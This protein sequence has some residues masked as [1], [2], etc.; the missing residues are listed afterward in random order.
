MVGSVNDISSGNLGLGVT[1][2]AWSSGYK[3]FQVTPVAVLASGTGNDA[4]FSNNWVNESGGNKYITSAAATLYSQY[5]GAHTWYTAA[6]GTAGDP[7]SFT[8]A[9][10][11]DASGNLLVGTTMTMVM[12]LSR[13]AAALMFIFAPHLQ[14]L[15]LPRFKYQAIVL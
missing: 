11:L 5:A 8:Q 9:M 7:I 4:V 15:T 6:S 12:C 14:G 3:A 10:T 13:K 2:S 1:P